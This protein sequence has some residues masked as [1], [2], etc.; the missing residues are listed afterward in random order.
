MGQSGTIA[1]TTD[2]PVASQPLRGQETDKKERKTTRTGPEP[3]LMRVNRLVPYQDQRRTP[4]EPTVS[5]LIRGSLAHIEGGPLVPPRSAV[6]TTTVRQI[7]WNV[8][9]VSVGILDSGRPERHPVCR[10][11]Y[12]VSSVA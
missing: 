4:F 9:G 10:S 2:R 11:W 7:L 5:D 3:H 8:N 12:K 1:N 6:S